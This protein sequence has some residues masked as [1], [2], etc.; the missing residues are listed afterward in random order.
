MSMNG[1]PLPLSPVDLHCHSTASDGSLP[2][3]ELVAAAAEAGVQVL[4]L[5]DHDTVDGLDEAYAAAQHHALRLVPGTELS[6][7]WAERSLH[8]V[9]LDIDPRAPALRAGLDE[10]RTIRAARAE[11]IAVKL[12]K[13]GVRDALARTQAL[14]GDA[15]PTRTHFA[16]LLVSDGL[17]RD[18]ERAFNR[19]LGAGK[20]AYVGAAWPQLDTAVA[21]IRSAGGRAVIAHPMRYRFGSQLRGRL[22]DA[23][24]EMGGSAIEVCCGTS[25]PEDIRRSAAEAVEHG[26]RGSVGSDFHGGEQPWVRLGRIAT[27]PAGVTPVLDP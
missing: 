8:L 16:R 5:T 15:Q 7:R 1:T 23:F 19:Y 25:S 9:G 26:L 17:C 6:V 22:Y 3:A 13:L 21:W 4:A 10:L 24:R 14:A 12:E 2:P 18:I 27:L 20:A 11:G